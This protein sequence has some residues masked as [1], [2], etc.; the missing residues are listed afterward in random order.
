MRSLEITLKICFLIL[1][2]F[3]LVTNNVLNSGLLALLLVSFILG[4]VL[5]INKKHPSYRHARAKSDFIMRKIEGVAL[6]VFAVAS[7]V[8]LIIS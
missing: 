8:A 5:I 1:S 6:I 4:I 7:T 2:V 3:I